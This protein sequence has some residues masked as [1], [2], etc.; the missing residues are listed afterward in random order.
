[1]PRQEKTVQYFVEKSITALNRCQIVKELRS[2]SNLVVKLLEKLQYKLPKWLSYASCV[3]AY[4]STHV[5]METK[6]SYG[7][8]KTLLF[9]KDVH[10]L[11]Q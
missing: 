1:M 5:L 3:D 7:S 10:I 6:G 4:M 2:S 11:L 8:F 9:S